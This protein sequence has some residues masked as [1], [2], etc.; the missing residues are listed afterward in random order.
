MAEFTYNNTKNASTGYNLFKFN[1]GYY[2]KVLFEENI[3]PYLRSCFAN[4]LVEELKELIEVC[5]Q[6]LFHGQELQKRVYNKRVKSCS[7]VLSKK[8]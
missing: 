2:L 1:C 7:Y 3:D 4:K 6:N 5:C 8:V